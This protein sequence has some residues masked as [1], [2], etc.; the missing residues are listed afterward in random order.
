MT[1]TLDTSR[2]SP[3][4]SSRGGADIS[5]IVLHA[6]VG[7]YDSALGWLCNYVSKA[8]TH[9]LIR[10]DG[11]IARLVYDNRAAWHAGRATWHGMAAEAIMRGSLGIEL[12]NRNTGKDTYPFAQLDTARQL[13]KYLIARYAIERAN[14]VRHLDI[15]KP[16][17]RK[18]DPAGFPW[19]A[20]VKSLY[21]L[22]GADMH[23]K[24]LKTVTGGAT[25]RSA[26]R[27]N[28][29]VLG[30]LKAGDPWSGEEIEGNMVTVHGFGSSRV[31]VRA[32]D[33]RCV[34]RNLL[35]E[36]KE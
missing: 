16:N 26:P 18:T 36:V 12:E 15:A 28:G 2:S 30:R 4:H 33:Q 8:S 24:V 29:M 1:Y 32:D 21:A 6:T 7:S 17:G 35:E 27:I 9:Y 3:N 11:H 34:W 13:C 10:K 22:P 31:W 19:T 14:V 25:I 23:Y 5:M 20:F